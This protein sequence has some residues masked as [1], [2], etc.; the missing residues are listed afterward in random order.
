MLLDPEIVARH[1]DFADGGLLSLAELNSEHIALL[2]GG[3]DP[4]IVDEDDIDDEDVSFFLDDVIVDPYDDSIVK[5]L[6]SQGDFARVEARALTDNSRYGEAKQWQDY[7]EA[8]SQQARNKFVDGFP[9]GQ[10]KAFGDKN[11]N[12]IRYNMVDTNG[13]PFVWTL[14]ARIKLKVTDQ[15]KLKNPVFYTDTLIEADDLKRAVENYFTNARLGGDGGFSFK[16]G[17]PIK[18]LTDKWGIN[19]NSNSG[20]LAYWTTIYRA[21]VA[22]AMAAEGPNAYVFLKLPWYTGVNPTTQNF[23]KYVYT[24]PKEKDEPQWGPGWTWYW[25]EMPALMRNKK[26]KAIW[27]VNPSPGKQNEVIPIWWWSGHT[28]LNNRYGLHPYRNRESMRYRKLDT[29]QGTDIYTDDEI[30]SYL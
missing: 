27:A 5:T 4:L 29:N 14:V 20:Q 28:E 19:K 11:G 10:T 13:A 17:T 24:P 30:P 25:A 1:D 8:I 16:S 2:Q 12:I 26:I 15:S 3:V 21:S 9:D 18:W 23:R 22:V 7:F 6:S